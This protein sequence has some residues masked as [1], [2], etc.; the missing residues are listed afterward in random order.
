MKKLNENRNELSVTRK[1]EIEELAE[2]VSECYCPTGVVNPRQIATCLGITFSEGNYKNCFDGALEYRSRKFH[3]YLNKER[4]GTNKERLRYSFA[5]ELGHYYINEHRNQL[6]KGKSLHKSYSH[7]V[8]KDIV[9]LEADYFAACLLM[10]KKRLRR[11]V[12][13]KKFDFSIV[14]LLKSEFEV[15]YSAILF[16]LLELNIY[17]IM[18]VYS[19]SNQLKHRWYSP[20]FEFKY[21]TNFNTSKQ[22][23]PNTVAGEYFTYGTKY[24]DKEEVNAK[25]WFDSY[26][27]ISNITLYERCIYVS[28]VNT[29]ISI[30][31]L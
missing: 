5:H 2:Y 1:I 26:D 3:I 13:T 21:I 30:L 22:L 24:N 6:I 20:D 10:P 7:L 8:Q 27:D 16:R 28:S 12:G 18:I 9:E 23:P 19:Q 15:S 14:E 29:V 31:W 25:D 17:S 4:V 11:I